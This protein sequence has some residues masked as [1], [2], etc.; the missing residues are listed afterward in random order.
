MP[1]AF[2]LAAVDESVCVTCLCVCVCACVCVLHFFFLFSCLPLSASHH[3]CVHVLA[4][5]VCH[6]PL[7]ENPLGPS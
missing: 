3:V 2:S 4:V 7:L 5:V 1:Q 6:I